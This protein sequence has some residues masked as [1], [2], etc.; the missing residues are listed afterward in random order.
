MYKHLDQEENMEKQPTE[1]GTSYDLSRNF[2][3]VDVASNLSRHASPLTINET[4]DKADRFYDPAKWALLY[5]YTKRVIHRDYH[6]EL[7]DFK[8][9]F[10][11]F[12]VHWTRHAW[13]KSNQT[14]CLIEAE[15]W[16]RSERNHTLGR[17]VRREKS[18]AL[19]VICSIMRN[20][21][22]EPHDSFHRSNLP[23]RT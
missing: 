4:I 13:F 6:E 3:I 7:R 23:F 19:M 9:Q 1:R 21:M 16:N 20:I 12:C 18:S 5:G 8:G 10:F 15:T 11:M 2:A 14:T 22:G 17:L